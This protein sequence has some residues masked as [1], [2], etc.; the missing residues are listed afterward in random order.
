M[1]NFLLSEEKLETSKKT[2]KPLEDDVDMFQDLQSENEVINYYNIY[3][4]FKILSCF[5][6][7]YVIKLKL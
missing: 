1:E 2:P 5:I 4:I 3:F 6:S 7:N